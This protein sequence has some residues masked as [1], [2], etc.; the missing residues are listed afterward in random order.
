M[1]ATN[2]TKIRSVLRRPMKPQAWSRQINYFLQWKGNFKAK[3]LYQLN[4][5]QGNT[6]EQAA[7]G[8]RLVRSSFIFLFFLRVNNDCNFFPVGSARRL[9]VW[10]RK[11]L[12][13]VLVSLIII[14]FSP[15][16]LCNSCKRNHYWLWILNLIMTEQSKYQL[17][18]VFHFVLFIKTP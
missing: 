14:L 6:T 18:E 8:G 11:T 2:V 12:T 7:F 10:R 5:T 16:S 1:P 3:C 15:L 17:Q 4:L 13:F 9:E